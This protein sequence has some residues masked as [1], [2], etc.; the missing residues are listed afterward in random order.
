MK[1]IKL[2]NSKKEVIIDDEDFDYFSRFK[3]YINKNGYAYR[4]METKGNRVI[5]YLS[6]LVIQGKSNTYI[7][8]KNGNILDNRKENLFHCYAG[9]KVQKGKKREK[10][11]SIYKGVSYNKET[12]KWVAKIGFNY[13]LI[14]LGYFLLETDAAKAY[15]KKALELHGEFAYQNIIL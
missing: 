5:L 11:S 3:W 13:K 10:L 7:S 9:N 15:N 2:Q 6:S 8:Y 4:Q 14:H 1:T 12:G